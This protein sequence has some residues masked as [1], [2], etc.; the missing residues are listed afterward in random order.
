MTRET[1][2]KGLFSGVKKK[3]KPPI[4]AVLSLFACDASAYEEV[5]NLGSEELTYWW[6]N[7]SPFVRISTDGKVLVTYLQDANGDIGL[8]VRRENGQMEYLSVPTGT[9]ALEARALSDDGT[10]L[11][12]NMVDEHGRRQQA[13][14]YADGKMTYLGHL[15]RGDSQ[16]V[17]IS[18]DGKVIAGN[19][20]AGTPGANTQGFI[21]TDKDGM[22]PLGFLANGTFS[23]V[24]AI[25]A[26]GRVIIGQGNTVGGTTRWKAFKYTESRK[27]VNLG[28]LP[29]MDGSDA[30]GVSANG[31]VIVGVATGSTAYVRVSRAFKYTDAGGMKDIHGLGDQSSAS[32]VSADGNV[33]IGTWSK[34]ATFELGSFKYTDKGSMINLGGLGGKHTNAVA[35]NA[36]GSIII[37]DAET[38]NGVTVAYRYTDQTGIVALQG[39][40][41]DYSSANAISADGKIILGNSRTTAGVL[42]A[43]LWKEKTILDQTN[44][45][46]TLSQAASQG[47][48]VLDARSAQLQALMQ[49]D[50]QIGS[51]GYCMGSGATYI[52][53]R[54]NREAVANLVIGTHLT[55]QWRIGANLSQGMDTSLPSNYKTANHVPGIGVFAQFNARK[56]GLGWRA[57]LG[58]AYQQS[59]V[60]I[61]RDQLAFTEIGSG[62][63]EIKGKAVSAEGS[64]R[65]ALRD[66]VMLEPYAALRYS[67]VSRSAYSESNEIAFIAHYAAMGREVN[68]VDAGVR[69][70][71]QISDKLNLAMDLGWTDDVAVDNRNFQVEMKYVGKINRGSGRDDRTR[72]HLAVQG[73]YALSVDSGIN[74]GISWSQQPYGNNAT[75]AQVMYVRQF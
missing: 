67:N 53:N 42:H 66:G 40:G 10:V 36:D 4:F 51:S 45:L 29:D 46:K 33:I 9:K 22:Q 21:Y 37:G 7:F 2:D 27:L 25:S 54:D 74:A 35:L 15:G 5:L 44:T 73:M 58:A 69:A 59:K 18:A 61:T 47:W 8:A 26:D 60:T 11:V 55:G 56:D 39:L 13:F 41:G 62:R 63:A 71:R 3:I 14:K 70:T 20:V 1:S 72:V 24:N 57:R 16:V 31:E 6:S 64:Y 30:L 12:G 50:C 34:T 28:T 17:G 32:D 43:V 75:N 23:R 68:S 48:N 52:N 38:A 49:Q 65:F 19:S